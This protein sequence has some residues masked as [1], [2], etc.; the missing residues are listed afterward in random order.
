M[1]IVLCGMMGVGKTS[2]GIEIARIS[3]RRWLDTDDVI[4]EKY[5]KISDIFE[6]YGEEYFRNIETK[7][8][9]DVSRAD[10]MVIST[11]GGAVLREENV[12][13]LKSGG[14]VIVYLKAEANTL[15]KRISPDDESRPLLSKKSEGAMRERIEELMAVRASVYERVADFVVPTDGKSIREVATEV[16][17]LV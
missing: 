8:I 17:A 6:F 7:T 9:K 1:N 2:V 16:L 10:N 11:G 4:T 15:L 13:L 12:N 14:C 3:G 5:G